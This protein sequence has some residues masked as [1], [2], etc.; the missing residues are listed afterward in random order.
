MYEA[1][2]KIAELAVA[3]GAAPINVL[4]DCWEYTVDE[5]WSI[6]VNGHDF[7]VGNIPS[8]CAMIWYNGFPA[9]LIHPVSGG[10]IAAGESAN[11]DTFITALDTRL[12]SLK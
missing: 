9:G 11:E 8:Y 2:N 5:K 6:Q 10:P 1:F 4:S 12:A 3:V 7:A